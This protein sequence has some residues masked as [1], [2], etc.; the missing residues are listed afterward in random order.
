ME[1]R[2]R[3]HPAAGRY[4]GHRGHQPGVA[5]RISQVWLTEGSVSLGMHPESKAPTVDLQKRYSVEVY[6]RF[7][8]L[9]ED[10][11]NTLE[12]TPEDYAEL[13]AKPVREALDRRKKPA[14]ART[15]PE[16]KRLKEADRKECDKRRPQLD[17]TKTRAQRKQDGLA[18]LQRIARRISN[19][20]LDKEALARTIIRG[21]LSPAV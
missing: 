5:D 2:A 15:A 12:L 10:D 16:T 1:G 8:P 21:G 18:A 9:F 11:V 4:G 7:D 14:A 19:P 6:N 3:K 17:M 20:D 13:V